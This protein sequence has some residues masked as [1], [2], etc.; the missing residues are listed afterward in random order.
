MDVRQALHDDRFRSLFPE[1]HH[2]IEKYVKQPKCGACAV[3]VVREILNKYPDRVAKYFPGRTVVRPEDEA[4]TLS[5]N[6]FTVINCHIDQLEDKLR[7]LPP[8]RKQLAITRYEDQVTVV[9][10]ELAVVF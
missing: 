9:I 4:K 10:N 6:N 3:P 8:G 5:E 7:R 1:L 2:E